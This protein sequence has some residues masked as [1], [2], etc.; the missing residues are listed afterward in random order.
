MLNR[1]RI[2]RWFVLSFLLCFGEMS[3]FAQESAVIDY[4]QSEQY[5]PE[6]LRKKLNQLKPGSYSQKLYSAY[7]NKLSENTPEFL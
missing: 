7:F 6:G 2:I 3:G 5:H 1:K 4:L